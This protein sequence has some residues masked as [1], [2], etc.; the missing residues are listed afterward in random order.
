MVVSDSEAGFRCIFGCLMYLWF[1]TG[2]SVEF[3]WADLVFGFGW[4]V[5]VVLVW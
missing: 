1:C 2:C 4:V 5:L 3:W